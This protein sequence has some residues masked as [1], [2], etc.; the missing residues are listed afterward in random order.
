LRL[1]SSGTAA[2]L[3]LV[4]LETGDWLLEIGSELF[5]FLPDRVMSI[6]GRGVW[7]YIGTI[8]AKIKKCFIK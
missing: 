2:K 5:R 8:K 4:R 6:L 3:R 1:V 7:K